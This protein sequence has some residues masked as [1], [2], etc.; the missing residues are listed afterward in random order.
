[1]K[2]PLL[3]ALACIPAAALAVATVSGQY[4]MTVNKDRLINAQ[5]EPYNWLMMNGDYASTRYS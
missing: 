5:N 4:T 1:M 3:S 2:R